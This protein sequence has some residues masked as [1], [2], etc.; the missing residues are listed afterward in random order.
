MLQAAQRLLWDRRINQTKLTNAVRLMSIKSN[1]N[2]PQNCFH[3]AMQLMHESCLADNCVP[4]N[5]SELKKKVRSLDLDVQT[6]DCCCS[7]CM[8]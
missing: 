2:M 1:Y 6:I 4:K 3:E 5:Y 7:G 8:L